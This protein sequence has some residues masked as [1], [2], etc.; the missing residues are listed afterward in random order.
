M[1]VRNAELGCW[2]WTWMRW[3]LDR[4][5]GRRTREA[6]LGGRQMPAAQRAVGTSVNRDSGP[7]HSN[8]TGQAAGTPGSAPRTADANSRSVSHA[9]LIVYIKSSCYF[10]NKHKFLVSTM[11][12]DHRWSQRCYAHISIATGGRPRKRTP[13]RAGWTCQGELTKSGPTLTQWF[14]WSRS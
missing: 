13:R 14:T 4:T 1:A 2:L 11:C 5:D 7:Y 10:V 9:A 8:I 12:C 3:A 6:M